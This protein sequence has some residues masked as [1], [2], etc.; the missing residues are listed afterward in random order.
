MR[1]QKAFTLIELL[2]VIAIIGLLS[3]IVLVSLNR[4]RA[5][6]RDAKRVGDLKQ[7]ANALEMFYD[8]T[9][10]YPGESSC[11]PDTSNADAVCA[12]T[13]NWWNA[14]GLSA[15]FLGH[16]ISEFIN[17]PVDPTNNSTY[18]YWY[19]PH[20]TVSGKKQ[21]Y[22]IRAFLEESGSW[23]NIRNGVQDDDPDCA[24]KCDSCW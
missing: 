4:A 23:Y 10:S 3:T 11:N 22:Y 21:G 24:T 17:L 9:G 5:K 6:A 16:N 12:L 14:N 1:K 2:V 13:S 8:V 19:E 15:N 18:Y 20:C 7:I